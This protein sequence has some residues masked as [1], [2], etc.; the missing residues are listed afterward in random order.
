MR[1]F[2][3]CKDFLTDFLTSIRTSR[4]FVSVFV[5]HN[6]FRDLLWLQSHCPLLQKWKDLGPRFW[7]RFSWRIP[8]L[9]GK[10]VPF[11]AEWSA[12]L[13]NL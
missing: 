4:A 10:P 5:S 6:R 13:T 7:P 1:H 12:S 9:H 8:A 3:C 11:P 2:S